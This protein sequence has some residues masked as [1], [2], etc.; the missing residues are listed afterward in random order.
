MENLIIGIG[1]TGGNAIR[2]LRYRMD[3]LNTDEKIEELY[4]DTLNKDLIKENKTED[5]DAVSGAYKT[6]RPWDPTKYVQYSG[7]DAFHKIQNDL[8]GHDAFVADQVVRD[9]RKNYRW[10]Q[11]NYYQKLKMGGVNFSVVEGAGRFRQFG[12]MVIDLNFDSVR[13]GLDNAIQQM[14]P[15]FKVHMV[16]SLA[17]GTGAGGAFDLAM[18]LRHV[19][20]AR[21]KIPHIYAYVVMGK[22][23]IEGIQSAD[24]RPEISAH[25]AAIRELFR[26]ENHDR[27]C[28]VVIRYQGQENRRVETKEKLFDT[29]FILDIE[30][31][32]GLKGNDLRFLGLYPSLADGIEI[33][34]NT[35]SHQQIAQIANNWPHNVHEMRMNR[36]HAGEVAEE[37]NWFCT[38][39]VKRILFPKQLYYIRARNTVI[40]D[41]LR[42]ILPL[43]NS[44]V[45]DDKIDPTG[46]NLGAVVGYSAYGTYVY[47]MLSQWNGNFLKTVQ[48]RRE[49]PGPFLTD[50]VVNKWNLYSPDDLIG[51]IFIKEL[52]GR[53]TTT[54]LLD[55]RFAGAEGCGSVSRADEL[56]DFFRNVDSVKTK[57][58]T[59]LRRKLSNTDH[60]HRNLIRAS[61]ALG[62]MRLLNREPEKVSGA[63]GFTRGV[64]DYLQ[65]YL[66]KVSTWIGTRS[67]YLEKEISKQDDAVTGARNDLRRK[68]SRKGQEAV[69]QAEDERLEYVKRFVANAKLGEFVSFAIEEAAAWSAILH[70]WCQ[71][72]VELETGS[73][74]AHLKSEIDYTE[75][76]LQE[77]A[78]SPFIHVGMPYH[79]QER[80][81]ADSKSFKNVNIEM[82]GY[83]REFLGALRSKALIGSWKQV[84][85]WGHGIEGIPED[86]RKMFKVPE[87]R[88]LP[89]PEL[90][91]R[92]PAG[93]AV[94]DAL[95]DAEQVKLRLDELI[96]AE[97]RSVHQ[98]FNVFGYLLSPGLHP[99]A[100][101]NDD[102]MGDI[103]GKTFLEAAP[104]LQFEPARGNRQPFLLYNSSSDPARIIAFVGKAGQTAKSYGAAETF[105]V[106][107]CGDGNSI[108]FVEYV[109][110]LEADDAPSLSSPKDAYIK[111]I[112]QV[113]ASPAAG[114]ALAGVLSNHIMPEEQEM[115]RFEIQEIAPRLS[116]TKFSKGDFIPVEMAPL[117]NDVERLNLF[118]RLWSC[119][120]IGRMPS[121]EQDAGTIGQEYVPIIFHT[122]PMEDK[123]VPVARRPFILSRSGSLLDAARAFVQNERNQDVEAAD[124]TLPDP[125]HLEHLLKQAIV[126]YWIPTTEKAKPKWA[127]ENSKVGGGPYGMQWRRLDRMKDRLRRDENADLFCVTYG[128]TRTEDKSSPRLERLRE[129]FLYYVESV[130]KWTIEMKNRIEGDK[131]DL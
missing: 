47:D 43:G 104:F 123:Q 70:H 41:W 79:E 75:R 101:G 74:R 109:V 78:M 1:G 37:P 113:A 32:D 92:I 59:E 89:K 40:L 125:T 53:D 116:G 23:F 33:L 61:V 77:L 51:Y 100:Q 27:T 91:L 65:D 50:Q 108:T 118:C 3:L 15:N 18:I 19:A 73:L 110:G 17:G 12:R 69:L 119:G 85:K 29:V 56:N 72:L 49:E 48:Y 10:F 38:Y 76:E 20:R 111:D 128:V 131:D 54:Q 129:I 24:A 103:L 122:T 25:Y 114:G 2:C 21:H 14:D 6:L 102:R 126:K 57:F 84:M 64:F 16:F 34:I 66:N 124:T 26:L 107:G 28:P 112:Q 96:S 97:S 31:L 11:A 58:D 94:G 127:E 81:G 106:D 95:K 67:H 105:L 83:Y 68:F 13:N 7:S 8:I 36:L 35:V 52:A 22:A 115:M 99:E 39:R 82:G 44:T 63:V 71:S 30:S 5:K 46:Q 121:N 55:L 86:E 42:E 130:Q 87:D 60:Y 98:G 93:E 80:G 45:V 88:E 120:L 9:R 4:V 117:F 62:A 90:Y